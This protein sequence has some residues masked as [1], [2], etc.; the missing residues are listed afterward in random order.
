MPLQPRKRTS[1]LRT[2]V[3][4]K[5]HIRTLAP[6]QTSGLFD[7]LIGDAEQRLR[8]REAERPGSR[9]IDDKFELGRLQNWQIGGLGPLEKAAR[10][11]AELAIHV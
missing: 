10:I 2:A 11:D 8:H 1:E 3:S 6:Q 9:Q 4:V 5:G 7:H